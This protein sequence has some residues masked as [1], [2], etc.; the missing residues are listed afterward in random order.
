VA[1]T[2]GNVF[3]RF[4]A[5]ILAIVT[6]FFSTISTF[7]STLFSISGPPAAPE[8]AS[9]QTSQS[10]AGADTTRRRGGH[11]AGVGRPDEGRK[12]QQFYNGNST[13]FEPRPD[14]GE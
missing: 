8:P 9:S 11:I 12:D 4:I 13:N 5:Y 14:D 10:Q 3:Q 1:T 2:Q 7:F 6:G